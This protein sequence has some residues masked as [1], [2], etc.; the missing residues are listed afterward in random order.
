MGWG[1]PTLASDLSVYAAASEPRLG[2]ELVRERVRW[3]GVMECSEVVGEG[4]GGSTC[5][6]RCLS[7]V[8]LGN[9]RGEAGAWLYCSQIRAFLTVKGHIVN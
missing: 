3:A 5:T 8:P 2:G 6:V 1:A 7:S 4:R 9:S